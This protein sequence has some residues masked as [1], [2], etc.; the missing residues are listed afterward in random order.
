MI[1]SPSETS[2]P[3]TSQPDTKGHFGPYGGRYVPEVLMAPLE[4]LENAYQEAQRDA[5]FSSEFSD[6]LDKYAGRPPPL[7]SAR[8]LSKSRG[9]ARLYLK[10]EDLLHTG[11]HKINNAL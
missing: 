7:Y 10:R 4:E 1:A 9:G 11:A 2:Q 3:E 8:R 5:S 6:L